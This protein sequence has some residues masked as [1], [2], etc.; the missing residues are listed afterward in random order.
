[1][2]GEPTAGPGMAHCC[3]TERLV[4]LIR[5]ARK[6]IVGEQKVTITPM[7]DSRGNPQG[8]P[9]IVA[10]GGTLRAGS[11][12]EKALRIALEAAAAKGAETLLISGSELDM[13]HFVPEH[14]GRS[15]NAKR[16]IGELRRANGII[17]G[18]PSYHGS[19]AGHIK[20]ALDYVEDMRE[21]SLPYFEA[22][23]VG[24]VATGAGWQGTVNTLSALRTI[25][26]A[27][28]GWNTPLGV[29]I[30]TAEPAFH[31]DGGCRDPTLQTS[32]A[33]IGEQVVSFA[34]QVAMAQAI[35]AGR[36]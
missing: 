15:S 33:M 19:I 28:R 7:F 17:I 14:P 18:S 6:L 22:R 10:F 9:Y 8:R 16:L 27:L 31:P 3:A 21:D 23:A 4:Q 25:V 24:S 11:S 29:A 35:E 30:N 34:L 36:S 2:R 5:L 32:L 1:V 20:N 12:T 13:P 26:H